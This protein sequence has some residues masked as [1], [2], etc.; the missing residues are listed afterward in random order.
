MILMTE[1]DAQRWQLP[2]NQDLKIVSSACASAEKTARKRSG[3][4]K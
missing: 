4:V 1:N 2:Q 3:N